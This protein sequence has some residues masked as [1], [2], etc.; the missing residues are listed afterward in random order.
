MEVRL[1]VRTLFVLSGVLL[2]AGGIG[3][4]VAHVLHL[5]YHPTHVSQIM[6]YVSKS[7]PV[8][9]LLFASVLL[10][11]L[12]L[13][14]VL[15]RQHEKTGVVGLIGF[16]FVYFGLMFGEGLHCVLE[17]GIYPAMAK[18]V[19]NEMISVIDQM[20][21][22][23]PY[24]FLEVGGSGLLLLGVLMLG[25]SMLKAGILP[26][27]TALLLLATDV[28]ALLAFIP[29]THRLIGGRFPVVLYL[30]FTGTGYS[31]L[32]ERSAQVQTKTLGHSVGRT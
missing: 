13:P 3:G 32:Q 31:L 1:S 7:E 10:V 27:W 11:M 12:G 26:R 22:G 21:H 16:V 14:G 15:I 2:I 29:V 19:P 30:A 25:A 23:S 24:A 28:A 5:Q 8:H 4:V 6:P 9:V 17:F 20:Y 18:Q